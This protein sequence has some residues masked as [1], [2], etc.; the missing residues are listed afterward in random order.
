MRHENEETAA[1][2]RY[3]DTQS[4]GTD[5]PWTDND[6]WCYILMC[7]GGIR[8]DK[9]YWDSHCTTGENRARYRYLDRVWGEGRSLDCLAQEIDAVWPWYGIKDAN[10]LWEWLGATA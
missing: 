5:N 9:D 6:L 8:R 1:E 7:A 10:D 4:G 3:L 2:M